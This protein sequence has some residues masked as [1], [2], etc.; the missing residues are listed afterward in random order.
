MQVVVATLQRGRHRQL[1]NQ[2]RG[3]LAQTLRPSRWIVVSMDPAPP[4]L[5]GW[6]AA[7]PALEVVP[8]PADPQR[9]LPLAAARNAAAA[10]AGAAGA[11]LLIMLD[12][13]CIPAPRLVE[14]YVAAAR[15]TGGGAI[16][17][18]PVGRLAAGDLHE[19]DGEDA[20]PLDRP[21]TLAAD[22]LAAARAR[23]P[24][25]FPAG[26]RLAP[27]D[28]PELFWS[29][30]Y[31]L[32]PSTHAQIGGYDEGYA[33]YGG[34]DTDFALNAA[35]AG[36]ELWTAGGAWAY[37]QHHPVS[38]PPREHLADI[39]RNARRFHARW[40]W[41]PMEGWLAA[42]ASEGLIEWRPGSDVL[43]ATTAR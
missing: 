1:R 12:V 27:L 42:F 3:L 9:P 39:V 17:L 4:P 37:H 14:R 26:T 24:R 25:P 41:W 10:C 31:A 6:P 23:E 2:G 20:P 38:S 18:G 40:G 13:D 35:R 30:S 34:E 28:R 16:V 19:R 36:V 15:A 7:A 22:E 43:R 8:H 21:L 32:A 33:G 5:A 29:L 11:E